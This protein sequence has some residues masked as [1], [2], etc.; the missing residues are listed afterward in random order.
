[1]K[2]EE[3]SSF[4]NNNLKI[5]IITSEWPT[6]QHPDSVPFLKH[7]V[8]D[9]RKMGIIVDVFT[10]RGS[11]NLFVYLKTWIK[12]HLLDKSEYDIF[13]AHWGQS[14]LLCFPTRTPVVVTFHGSDLQGLVKPNGEYD[15][16]KSFLIRLAS[17][18]SANLSTRIIIVSEL[19]GNYLPCKDIKKTTIIPCGI[20]LERFSPI[21]KTIARQKLGLPLN[22]KIV[23]F[24]ANPK[25]TV[26]RYQLAEKVISLISSEFDV[27]LIS[28]SSVQHNLVPY[29]MN[30]SDVM[31]LTSKHEGSPMVVKEALG[32]NL[33]I[34]SVN[35]GDVKERILLVPGCVVSNS[36][37][38]IELANNIKKV[39]KRNKRIDGRSF[40]TD[41]SRP[42]IAN[43]IINI[44]NELLS[45]K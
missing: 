36:D 37:N 8:D 7:Q 39:L 42:I 17:K 11:G 33:P 4:K 35:V 27:E 24:P 13:H 38:P 32:C 9:L 25:D 23:L 19:L 41:L 14:G 6:L 22:K 34:V 45:T 21:D 2:K 1:M 43:K 3:T 20:D 16:L 30:A 28:L 31:L 18:I 29:Y 40:V 26:K 15:S 10:F 44:Y 5:L 12:F